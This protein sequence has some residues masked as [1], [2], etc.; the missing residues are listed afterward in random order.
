M[1]NL[2][3]QVALV[4]ESKSIDLPEVTRVAAALD[5]QATRDFGPIWGVNSSIHAF[6]SLEEVPLGYWPMIIQDDIGFQGRGH[7]S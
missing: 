2:I 5:K 7:S 4:S 6:A 1:P 3:Q